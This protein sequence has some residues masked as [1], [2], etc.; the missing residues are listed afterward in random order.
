MPL[1]ARAPEMREQEA[2]CRAPHAHRG[3]RPGRESSA[4][5]TFACIR[6]MLLR[7]Q[8]PDGWRP[9]RAAVHQ[10]YIPRAE[11]GGRRQSPVRVHFLGVPP[12]VGAFF[13]VVM[14]D[15]SGRWERVSHCIDGASE[16]TRV[17]H[18]CG[19]P[20]PR[21]GHRRGRSGCSRE[22]AARRNL[23][24]SAQP[25]RSPTVC[26]KASAATDGVTR[27]KSQGVVAGIRAPGVRRPGHG[28]SSLVTTGSRFRGA[29]WT[30]AEVVTSV[31]AT[32]LGRSGMVLCVQVDLLRSLGARCLH[33]SSLPL[34]VCC[35]VWSTP[36]RTR[37]PVMFRPMLVWTLR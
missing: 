34:G 6:A 20:Q 13:P 27:L 19:R 37:P 31:G 29:A 2:R 5:L 32:N 3:A 12:R 23:S 1:D 9:L 22:P 21:S 36:D 8:M 33:E 30:C 14:P 25:V 24:L 7:E 10:K 26:G 4:K 15:S 35:A 17:G 18:S 11:A 28:A 16:S